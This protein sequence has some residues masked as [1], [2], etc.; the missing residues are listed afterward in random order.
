MRHSAESPP[1]LLPVSF[2]QA[3][4]WLLRQ[5]K[6][7]SEALQT[8]AVNEHEREVIADLNRSLAE[9]PA[10]TA[11]LQEQP[12]RPASPV[13]PT[14]VMSLGPE[15]VTDHVR[16]EERAKERAHRQAQEPP[17]KKKAIQVKKKI[18]PLE[19]EE[20]QKRASA[21]MLELGVPP[22]QA[23]INFLL[24]VIVCLIK[25]CHLCIITYYT[26]PCTA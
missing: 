12:A 25:T 13:V 5:H 14:P 2:A 1:A 20:W 19:L 24:L 3:K 9:Q 6:A 23:R 22:L 21:R 11:A 16:A 26:F 17:R 18:I 7:Q 8:G 10:S 15:P 4:D